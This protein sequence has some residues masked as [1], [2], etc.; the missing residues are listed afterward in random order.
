MLVVSTQSDCAGVGFHTKFRFVLLPA[1][2]QRQK[3]AQSSFCNL[4]V[5]QFATVGIYKVANA[6]Q[7]SCGTNLAIFSNRDAAC[8]ACTIFMK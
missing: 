7:L 6:C 4:V 8:C 2:L 1:S 3:E 5:K